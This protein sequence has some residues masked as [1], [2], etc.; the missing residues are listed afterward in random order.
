MDKFQGHY[1]KWNK[2]FVKKTN[3]AWFHLCEVL[4]TIWGVVKIIKTESR[5][6][7]VMGSRERRM[8]SYYLISTE[9]QF[10]KM[11]RVMGLGGGDGC[12]ECI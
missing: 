11:K 10:Y 3:T 5:M 1:T 12:Y 2:P 6:V 9:F 7:I 8:K 4:G